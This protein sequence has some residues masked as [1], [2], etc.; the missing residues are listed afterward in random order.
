MRLG[1]KPIAAQHANHS[2]DGVRVRGPRLDLERMFR[3]A[4]CLFE[5]HRRRQANIGGQQM[6]IRQAGPTEREIRVDLQCGLEPLD[7]AAAVFNRGSL[8]QT[9]RLPKELQ[10]LIVAGH[11]AGFG[12]HP[13]RSRFDAYV[14]DESVA[15]PRHRLDE[16][17]LSG[18]LLEKSPQLHDVLTQVVRLDVGIGPNRVHERVAGEQGAAMLNQVNQSVQH[19]RRRAHTP[20]GSQ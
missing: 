12:R 10:R 6:S 5:Q 17:I 3:M 2:D 15:A 14:G 11:V 16:A 4:L 1:R 9:Q 8:Q 20:P 19:A 7:G 18:P 13:E